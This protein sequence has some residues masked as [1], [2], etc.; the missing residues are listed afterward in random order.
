MY[1]CL[2]VCCMYLY[3]L[4]SLS[5]FLYLFFLSFFPYCRRRRRPSGSGS[6]SSS[7]YQQRRQKTSLILFVCSSPFLL[8]KRAPRCSCWCNITIC[9]TSI[10]YGIRHYISFL[11]SSTALPY[12]TR[13]VSSSPCKY[14][15]QWI[16]LH[17]I[18]VLC[19]VRKLCSED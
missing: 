16:I 7:W 14:C 11:S 10:L 6:H 19:M 9:R 3:S 2:S 1:V 17:C 12:P 18:V 8:W 13:D 4:I 15:K 5:F